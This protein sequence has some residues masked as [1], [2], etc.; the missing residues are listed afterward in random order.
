M[1]RWANE[2]LPWIPK[3]YNA[4]VHD[5]AQLKGP[6]RTFRLYVSG[7]TPM[8]MQLA[9][10]LKIALDILGPALEQDGIRYEGILDHCC[11]EGWCFFTALNERNWYIGN[12]TAGAGRGI[13]ND[14]EAY[15]YVE[16]LADQGS[17][18]HQAALGALAALNMVTA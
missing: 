1:R 13:T 16:R 5:A 9:E 2:F 14:L 8:G 15:R 4:A 10:Q 7:V 3:A 11:A 6:L 18:F 12:T 17:A